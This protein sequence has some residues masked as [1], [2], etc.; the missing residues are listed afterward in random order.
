MNS[1]SRH[2][3]WI[4]IYL[5]HK[6][7]F[8]HAFLLGFFINCLAL[9]VP[10]H[11]L[12]VYDRV[13]TSAHL[14]TLLV[15]TAIVMAALVF[16]SGFDYL[17][18]KLLLSLAEEFETSYRKIIFQAS[19]AESYRRDKATNLPY[20][21]LCNTAKTFFASPWMAAIIDLPWVPIY[22]LVIYQFHPWL[23]IA[24][25]TACA[26]MIIIAVV[27]YK[28]TKSATEKSSN[29]GGQAR[30]YLEVSIRNAEAI[31]GLGMMKNAFARWG[32]KLV[33]AEGSSSTAQEISSKG[34]YLSKFFRLALQVFMLS[35]GAYLVISQEMSAGGI[36]ANSIMLNKAL[37]GFDL[38]SAGWK[39]LQETGF[40]LEQLSA[41]DK[42][43]RAVESDSPK[44]LRPP[45]GRL[46]AKDLGYLAPISRKPILNGVGFSL[47]K[48]DTL[49]IIGPSGS[50]KSTLVRLLI[51][52]L[53]PSRGTCQ[54]DGAPAHLLDDDYFRLHVG[55]L[56]QQV[57]LYP[58]T[59]SENICRLGEA[60][61]DLILS[62]AEMAGCYQ[63]IMSLPQGFDT[64][65][66]RLGG[67][68]SLGQQQRIA[69]ARALY[70][71]P[72][73][74]ILDEPNANLDA[75]GDEALRQAVVKAAAAG[76]TTIMVVHR[77]SMLQVC[78]KVL[79]IRGGQQAAFGPRDEI[80]KR[81]GPEARQ[82]V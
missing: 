74:L 72:A 43:K 68:L 44:I 48:G 9:A 60:D 11:M 32:E 37:A 75:E 4:H 20:W 56:P 25:I 34:V 51:G 46:T 39:N 13:L 69:L 22:I 31:R 62:A 63:M 29:L 64:P 38:I 33:E 18:H 70:G 54:H 79:L 21:N 53:E 15:I 61:P 57:L 80:L 65:V 10:L 78:N 3:S 23:G 1:P 71:K 19:I 82:A 67:N 7:L 36:V 30:E 42:N 52:A 73:F 27:N 5:S 2:S 77:S 58:G 55:Y 24:S 76:T 66:G 49:A 8:N 14:E 35:L 6:T 26:L 40:A 59:I 47:D 41:L 50:G 28:V 12:Q 81:T 17:R 45:E 16:Q